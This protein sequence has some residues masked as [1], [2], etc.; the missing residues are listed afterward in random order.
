MRTPTGA[1]SPSAPAASSSKMPDTSPTPRRMPSHRSAA[2]DYSS[3]PFWSSVADVAARPLCLLHFLVPECLTPLASAAQTGSSRPQSAR[4]DSRQIS[5]KLRCVDAG[6][7]KHTPLRI[8]LR[9]HL[10]TRLER[11]TPRIRLLFVAPRSWIW[12][13]LDPISQ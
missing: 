5:Q 2:G 12:L 9:C 8:G 10:P 1:S 13:L 4:A 3:L 7:I 11:T 6:L